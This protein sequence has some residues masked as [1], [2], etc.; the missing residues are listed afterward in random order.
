MSGGFIIV[1]LVFY[2]SWAGCGNKRLWIVYGRR[3]RLN[4]RSRLR[5]GKYM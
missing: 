5:S 4:S 2:F 3:V 1:Y